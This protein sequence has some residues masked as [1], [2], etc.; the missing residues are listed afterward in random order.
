MPKDKGPEWNHVTIVEDAAGKGSAYVTMRCLY[1]DKA[2][3][4]GVNR[5]RSHLVGGDTFISKCDKATEE[6]VTA[7]KTVANEKTQRDHNKKKRVKLHNLTKG[8]GS[9]A[10]K[11]QKAVTQTSIT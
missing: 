6:V 11:G 2:Y 5:I 3:S 1:C 4:G 9:A 10:T 7:M 8:A